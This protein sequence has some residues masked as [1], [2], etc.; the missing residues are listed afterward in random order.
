MAY[1]VAF[2][3]EDENFFVFGYLSFFAQITINVV[4]LETWSFSLAPEAVTL[5]LI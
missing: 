2:N 1:K 5:L 3:T 4:V